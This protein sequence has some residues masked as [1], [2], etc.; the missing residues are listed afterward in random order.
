[1][2]YTQFSDKFAVQTFDT[3]ELVPLG[4]YKVS[5]TTE[6]Y[7][8][9]L[10]LFKQGTAGGSETLTLRIYGTS[11]Y[12]GTPIATSAA[13][14]LSTLSGIVAANWIGNARFTFATR[15]N[16]NPKLTYFFAL[17]TTSY[18]RNANTYYLGAVLDWPNPINTITGAGP[19]A[20]LA[21]VGYR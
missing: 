14:S 10:D 18:T 16:L 12:A 17:A 13:V 8:A 9:V 2:A 5:T 1:M 7:Y 21:L 20:K 6:L 19:A 11:A 15:P 4:C 3:S